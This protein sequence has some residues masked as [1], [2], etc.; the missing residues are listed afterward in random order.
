M[1][2]TAERE[3]VDAGQEASATRTVPRH[4]DRSPVH[5]AGVPLFLMPPLARTGVRIQRKPDDPSPAAPAPAPGLIVDDAATPG[6]LTKGE[7]MAQLRTEV[8]A[9][10]EDALAGTHWSAVGCPWIDR[11]FDYYGGQSSEHIEKALHRYAP[12]AAGASTAADYIPIV[13]AR[14]REAIS[15]WSATGETPALPE[16][17]AASGA[18][19]GQVQMK[20]DGAGA[21]G[22]SVRSRL[23]RG[24]PMDGGARTRMEGAFGADFSGVRV[25]NDPS[26]ARAARDLNARAFTIGNDVAFGRDQYQPGTMAGDAL[27]AHEFAHVVQQRGGGPVADAGT[28]PSNLEEEADHSAVGAVARLW[29]GAIDGLAGIAEN[30]MPRLRSGLRLQRCGEAPSIESLELPAEKKP[31]SA[32]EAADRIAKL[33]KGSTGDPEEHQILGIMLALEPKQYAELMTKLAAI[34]EGGTPLIGRLYEDMDGAELQIYR[35]INKAKLLAAKAGSPE[36]MEETLAALE[37]GEGTVGEYRYDPSKFTSP[38]TWGERAIIWKGGYTSEGKA[39]F[40]ESYWNWTLGSEE[41]SHEKMGPTDFAVLKEGPSGKRSVVTGLDLVALADAHESDYFWSNVNV[42]GIFV[43]AG[44]I[45]AA[46]TTLGKVAVGVFEVAIP[47][48]GQYVSDHQDEIAA[49]QGGKEFLRAW[50]IFNLAMAG[51][52]IGRLAWGSG[53]AVVDRVRTSGKAVAEGNP[54]SAIAAEIGEQANTGDEAF[55]EAAI[56]ALLETAGYKPSQIDTFTKVFEKAGVNTERLGGLSEDTLTALRQADDA[57]KEGLLSDAIQKLDSATEL[58][59]A[60]RSALASAMSKERGVDDIGSFRGTKDLD[61]DKIAALRQVGTALESQFPI[62][63]QLPLSPPAISRIVSKGPDVNAMKGQLLEELAATLVSQSMATS[64]GRAKLGLTGASGDA[65]F[66]E[67]HRIQDAAGR[68]ITDGMIAVKEGDKY[69]ILTVIEAKAGKGAAKGLS[70]SSAA[71]KSMSR[72]DRE[73]MFRVIAESADEKTKAFIK[74]KFPD[75]L[76][77]FENGRISKLSDEVIDEVN[78]NRTLRSSEAK[79]T[80]TEVGGQVTRDVER[81]YPNVDETSTTLKIDGQSVEVTLSPTKT[82]FIGALPSDVPS[83]GITKTLTDINYNFA[84]EA[85]GISQKD[86][87]KL[88]EEFFQRTQAGSP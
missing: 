3:G 26:A 8:C 51:F 34:K 30:A 66:I 71:I 19:D 20:G 33:L 68:Q 13:T 40:T 39:K 18:D 2:R 72:A 41:R 16:G 36:K 56:P 6:Q 47:A 11:W 42:I 5:E 4:E 23:G 22:S 14:I 38:S 54:S 28:G 64:A 29:G 77:D 25:H 48:A 61:K 1:S 53:R 76:D 83:G 87:I 7:F 12:Q 63:K 32:D 49:L 59:E 79:L 21:T 35:E 45:S 81:L 44:A 57:A 52:G 65:V 43:G 69:R 60:E 9:A 31:K 10:A 84:A 73:E 70:K 46:K 27:I 62:L 15:T 67:G 82:K 17:A 74:K 75:A 37:K 55:E 88:A 58:S 85:L 50:Q 24:A 80:A 78:T 86:L